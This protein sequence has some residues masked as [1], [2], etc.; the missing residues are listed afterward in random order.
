VH[1]DEISKAGF[2]HDGPTPDA[3]DKQMRSIRW[4]E[5]YPG[6]VSFRHLGQIRIFLKGQG[7]TFIDLTIKKTGR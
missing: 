5:T 6:L 3:P 4:I 1:L 7:F 2:Y